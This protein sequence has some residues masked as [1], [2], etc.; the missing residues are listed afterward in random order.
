[1]VVDLD[2]VSAAVIAG[3]GDPTDE[4]LLT[5]LGADDD[6]LADGDVGA[7]VDGKLGQGCDR[8]VDRG[9]LTL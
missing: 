6:R 3:G 1:V 8:S 7:G 4:P 9:R 5:E 2:L